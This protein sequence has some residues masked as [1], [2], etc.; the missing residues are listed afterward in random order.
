M[1][2]SFLAFLLYIKYMFHFVFMKSIHHENGAHSMLVRLFACL[3]GGRSSVYASVEFDI[4]CMK[5]GGG[6][7]SVE[8]FS[9]ATKI[10]SAKRLE[11]LM[12]L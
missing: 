10:N 5:G 12:K 6:G 7:G 1:G 2:G 8:A 11:E 3:A 4:Y 9:G